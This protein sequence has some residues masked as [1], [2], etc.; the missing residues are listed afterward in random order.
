M[1]G[2]GRGFTLGALHSEPSNAPP[3]AGRGRGLGLPSS[4][5][6]TVGRGRGLGLLSS[7]SPTLVRGRGLGLLSSLSIGTRGG[8][9]GAGALALAQAVMARRNP[10]P[11]PAVA[12]TYS[13]RPDTIASKEG[14]SGTPV[15]LSANYF[16]LNQNQ[17]FEFNLYRVDFLPD[18]EDVRLRR[19]YLSQHKE[20][21]GGYLFDGQNLL[22]TTRSLK[23]DNTQLES[24]NRE[25][26]VT[27]VTLRN[28]RRTIEMTDSSAVQVLN[29]ILR[30]AM[31]GLGMQ[32]VG[33][34]LYDPGNKVRT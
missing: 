29:L 6:P 34:N 17:E 8:G 23:S 19:F 33:R 25:G 11:E 28:T 9:R 26:D 18:T 5:S 24:V 14:S 4:P 10:T 22:Y 16:K 31:D 7:S 27:R 3:T 15:S 12:K 2:R 13:T 30:R 1:R 32:L 21:L 20:D